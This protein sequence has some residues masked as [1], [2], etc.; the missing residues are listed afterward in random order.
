M[1]QTASNPLLN[2]SAIH[3]A[4]SE[5]EQSCD[6]DEYLSACR[7]RAKKVYQRFGVTELRYLEY[8]RE[9]QAV[10][11]ATTPGVVLSTGAHGPSNPTLDKQGKLEALRQAY[12]DDLRRYH[13]VRGV[14]DWLQEHDPDA[15]K[16]VDLCYW[17]RRSRAWI[18]SHGDEAGLYLSERTFERKI[19]FAKDVLCEAMGWL[20]LDDLAPK[21]GGNVAEIEGESERK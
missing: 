15:A 18:L 7:A 6:F 5:P 14:L 17:Q 11:E 1:M 3:Y 13:A 21:N 16:L 4:F 12:K 10:I 8:L 20:S 9:R 2:R 19:Q